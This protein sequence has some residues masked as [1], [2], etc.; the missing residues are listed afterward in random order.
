MSDA[1]Y[2]GWWEVGEERGAAVA[3][4]TIRAFTTSAYAFAAGASAIYL[5]RDVAEA[6]AFKLAHAGVLAMGEDGG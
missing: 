3:I 5:V 1:R 6:L 2:L 4:D